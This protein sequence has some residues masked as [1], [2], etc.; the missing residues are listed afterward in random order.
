[1]SV[2]KIKAINPAISN[3]SWYKGPVSAVNKTVQEQG[4]FVQG[5]PNHPESRNYD[6]FAGAAKG[7]NVY[8]LA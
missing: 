6:K 5:N 4:N 3:I 7:L 1:M 8:Y 2:G